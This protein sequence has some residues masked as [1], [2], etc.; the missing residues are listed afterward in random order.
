MSEHLTF[1]S[2]M[3]LCIFM[4]AFLTLFNYKLGYI[5]LNEPILDSDG[6]LSVVC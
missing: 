4:H 5:I 6:E 3:Q 2:V 1:V